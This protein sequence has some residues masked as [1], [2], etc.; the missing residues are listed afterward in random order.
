MLRSTSD[1]ID[2]SLGMAPVMKNGHVIWKFNIFFVVYSMQ[3]IQHL[4]QQL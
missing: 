2:R 3:I 4:I 1:F